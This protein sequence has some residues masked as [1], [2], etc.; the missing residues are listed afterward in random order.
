MQRVAGH[1]QV[2]RLRLEYKVLNRHSYRRDGPQPPAPGLGLQSVSHRGADVDPGHVSAL[3]GKREAN[4]SSTASEVQHRI[5]RPHRG[6]REN[7]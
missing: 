2:K 5:A 6:R 1:Y 4:L 7:R 3:S